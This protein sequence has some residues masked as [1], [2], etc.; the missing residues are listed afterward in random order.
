MKSPTLCGNK[1]NNR[2]KKICEVTSKTN[3]NVGIKHLDLAWTAY[4]KSESLVVTS[5]VCT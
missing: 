4:T 3:A 1:K 2:K 5:L